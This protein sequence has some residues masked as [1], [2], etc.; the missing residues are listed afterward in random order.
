MDNKQGHVQAPINNT[1]MPSVWMIQ[2]SSCWPTFPSLA[3]IGN[4]ALRE[5][6]SARG[7]HVTGLW[8]GDVQ[9]QDKQAYALP[10]SFV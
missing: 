6:G 10:C 5:G 4:L 2:F 3:P 7:V 9:Q 1:D 8:C